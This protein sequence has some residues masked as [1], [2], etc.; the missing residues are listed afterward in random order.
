MSTL[1]LYSDTPTPPASTESTGSSTESHNTA[2]LSSPPDTPVHPPPSPNHTMPSDRNDKDFDHASS[3]NPAL[4]PY[5]DDQSGR[6]MRGSEEIDIMEPAPHRI[7]I[8]DEFRGIL[9]EKW[10]RLFNDEQMVK[11]GLAIEKAA[12]PMRCKALAEERLNR[13]LEEYNIASASRG[14][15]DRRHTQ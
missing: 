12:H 4:E 15:I 14:P 2:L 10:G 5:V 11:E 9:K 13:F 7:S 6:L 3:S 8:G 1:A